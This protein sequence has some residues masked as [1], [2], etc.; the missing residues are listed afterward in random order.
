[1]KNYRHLKL[2]SI[3]EAIALITLCRPDKKNALNL[4]MIEELSMVFEEL[5]TLRTYRVVIINAE[6][7]TFCSGLDLREA[8]DPKI[9]EK[10]ALSIARVFKAIYGSQIVTIAAVQGDAIAGGA[11]LLVAS[12]FVVMAKTART[13]FPETRRGLVAAQVATL[14]IRQVR[15]R[16]VREL[17]LLGEVIDSQQAL[18]MGIANRVVDEKQVLSEAINVAKEILKGAPKALQ[19]TKR[20]LENLEPNQFSEDLKIALSFNKEARESEEAKEGIAAFLEKRQPAWHK[21]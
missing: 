8:V 9:A 16:D 18:A 20:L 14:L 3:N 7:S 6:G 1:M 10:M 2:E 21:E 19:E 17:L 15:M 13:G 4:R 11:G 12:D 5:Q